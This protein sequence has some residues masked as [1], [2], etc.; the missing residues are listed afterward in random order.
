MPQ[1]DA[2]HLLEQAALM[3]E[4]AE[5]ESAPTHLRRAISNVYYALFHGVVQA[6]TD[7]FL[8]KR[9]RPSSRYVLLYRSVEHRHLRRLCEDI[10]K[11]TLPERLRKFFPNDKVHR[12]LAT[13]AQAF[14]YQQDRRMFADYDPSFEPIASDIAVEMQRA[15]A[16]LRSL[17]RIGPAER[18]A[19]FTLV[20]LRP[21]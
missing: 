11:S 1:P 8:G 4:H 2:Q 9:Q 6:A 21:Q 5:G 10:T 18:R 7:D 16:A 17:H 13:F 12:E 20:V 15:H 14:V 3:V 19:F